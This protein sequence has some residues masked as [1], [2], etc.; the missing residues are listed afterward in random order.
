MLISK[1][2]FRHTNK[3]K[4]GN[5]FKERGLTVS[6]SH[7]VLLSAEG[8]MEKE[9]ERESGEEEKRWTGSAATAP[10]TDTGRRLRHPVGGASGTEQRKKPV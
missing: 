4:D 5:S 9:R 2:S 1:L 3:T 8:V 7:P 6:A 10:H